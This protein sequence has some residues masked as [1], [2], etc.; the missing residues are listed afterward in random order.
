MTLVG[1][2]DDTDTGGAP[3][4]GGA[5]SSSAAYNDADATFVETMLPHHDQAISMSELLLAKSGVEAEVRALAEQVVATQQP[6]VDTMNAWLTAWQP[7]GSASHG[8]HSHGG[9]G[10]M[11]SE[12]QMKQLD[13]ADVASG[14]R[15]YLER[16]IAHH[17][18]AIAMAQ[19]EV[20]QGRAPEA[21][22]LARSVVAGQQAEIATMRALLNG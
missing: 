18:G 20:D 4:P 13:E 2:A 19:T 17:E 7:T 12:D 1:C 5:T 10:G 22:A 14:Q 6:E 8:E 11:L 16:M 21:V 15:L 9:Q 3:A